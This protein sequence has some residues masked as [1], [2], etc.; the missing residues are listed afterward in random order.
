[1]KDYLNILVTETSCGTRFTVSNEI[2]KANFRNYMA[3][4]FYVDVG[5]EVGSLGEEIIDSVQRIIPFTEIDLFPHEIILY[6]IMRLSGDT[7][8]RITEAIKVAI[9][10]K[11]TRVYNEK[12]PLGD[13]SKFRFEV[14]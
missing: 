10:R 1:M 6:P 9:N 13:Q 2:S 8:Q 3:D 11:F 12:F 4:S 14:S 5:C 7:I